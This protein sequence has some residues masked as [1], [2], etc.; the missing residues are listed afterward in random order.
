MP[1]HHLGDRGGEDRSGERPPEPESAG[2]VV[3]R[4]PRLQLVDEPEP[5]LGEGERQLRRPRSPLSP[6]GPARDR[7]AGRRALPRRPSLDACDPRRQ[8]GDRRRF[9]DRPHR[10]LHPEGGAQARHHL[11]GEERV[12]AEREE[13][14]ARSQGFGRPPEHLRPDRRHRRFEAPLGR[15]SLAFAGR[16]GAE[17][18]HL[19]QGRQ[20]LPVDLAV[21]RQRQGAEKSDR[22][23]HVLGQPAA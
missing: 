22:G 7:S 9:E 5:L 8:G 19:R 18:D 11:G 12:A 6:E 21:G 2:Q 23:D 20:G 14:V 17:S 13:V 1:P 16:P 15:Y 4:A 10:E 3:G